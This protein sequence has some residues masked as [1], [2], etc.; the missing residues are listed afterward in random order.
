MAQVSP[1]KRR[2]RRLRRTVTQARR[3]LAKSLEHR[4]YLT[5]Q[6]QQLIGVINAKKEETG[7]QSD[8]KYEL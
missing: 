3:L 5:G 2:E 7:V 1:R 4:Q 6:V 8:G